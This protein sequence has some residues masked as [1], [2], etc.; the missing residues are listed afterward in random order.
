MLTSIGSGEKYISKGA[1]LILQG[2]VVAFPTETVY[3]LGA[4]AF[5]NEAIKK[6]YEAKGRPADNPLI[7]HLTDFEELNGIAEDMPDVAYELFKACC[8]GPLTMFL[9]KSTKISEG[10]T[11]GLKTVGVRF[12]SH[13]VARELIRRSTAIAAPSANRSKHVSPTTAQHVLEDLNGRIP[14][15]IDGGASN[16]GIESTIIDLTGISPVILRPGMITLEAIEKIVNVKNFDKKIKTALAP[17][18]KYIHYSPYSDCIIADGIDEIEKLYKENMNK[19]IKTLILASD[20]TVNK[21]KYSDAW[22]LGD[23]GEEAAYRLYSL[24]RKGE[25]NYDLI[26]IENLGEK[27]AFYSVMNR[28]KKAAKRE[29]R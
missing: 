7:V 3:G 10:V 2:E 9:K 28:I 18:M 12:P 26:I 4:N 27:G 19:G 13:P 29:I 17:G 15:I 21:L 20:L 14:L 22:S 16:V 11:A 1:E 5:N 25:K 6:I 8:P 23:N 24:L